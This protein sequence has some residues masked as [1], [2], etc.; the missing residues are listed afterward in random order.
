MV[1]PVLPAVIAII[2]GVVVGTGMF[3]PFVALSYRRR[4]RLSA[5]RLLL[6]SAALVYFW[7]LWAYTLLPLPSGAELQ[8]VGTNLDVFE[9]V[10][11]LREAAG[12]SGSLLT[13]PAVLQLALN[14]VLFVPLRFLVRVL[15]CRR[16]GVAILTSLGPSLLIEL[17]QLT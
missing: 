5:G 13:D 4:G 15:G 9:L 3:V 14:V 10:G 7:A 11:T 16:T 8:C 2:T 1:G 12:R 17:A 6:W